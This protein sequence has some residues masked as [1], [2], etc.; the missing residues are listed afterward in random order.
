MLWGNTPFKFL[1]ANATDKDRTNYFHLENSYVGCRWLVLIGSILKLGWSYGIGVIYGAYTVEDLNSMYN[2]LSEVF[3]N[4]S[5]PILIMG[6][7]NQI[8]SVEVRR[9]QT[10]E[11]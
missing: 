4:V 5:V 11:N 9:G 1:V 7:F 2:E 10:I 8:L 6:D 3:Q